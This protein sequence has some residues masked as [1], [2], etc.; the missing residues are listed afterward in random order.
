VSREEIEAL[1]LQGDIA[2]YPDVRHSEGEE[3]HLAIGKSP[4]GRWLFIAFTVRILD[5][6]KLLRPLSARYMHRRE[7]QHYVRQGQA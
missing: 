2:T 5:G 7:I 3:R 4:E 1:F 6:T